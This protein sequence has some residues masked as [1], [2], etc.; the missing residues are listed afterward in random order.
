[1]KPGVGTH[2]TSELLATDKK[3][4]KSP[5]LV[6]CILLW[7]SAGGLL[8][9]GDSLTYK[10]CPICFL[11]SPSKQQFVEKK[12]PHSNV[13]DGLLLHTWE[14]VVNVRHGKGGGLMSD[15]QGKPWSI[16]LVSNFLTYHPLIFCSNK[17]CCQLTTLL[18]AVT[19]PGKQ[20]TVCYN[21][22]GSQC[23]LT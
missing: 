3:D 21:D 13:E 22:L 5:D 9:Q 4:I 19:P 1:M 10:S 23:H 6:Q 18:V 12:K 16:N 8:M 7:T 2:P 20:V 15:S 17:T 14:L 11:S